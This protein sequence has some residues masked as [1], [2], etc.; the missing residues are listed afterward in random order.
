MERV[1]ALLEQNNCHLGDY[2]IYHRHIRVNG[3]PRLFF[4]VANGEEPGVIDAA[5]AQGHTSCL[6]FFVNVATSYDGR[7]AFDAMLATAHNVAQACNVHV[8]DADRNRLT[9]QHVE[10]LYERIH[11]IER[12]R[13]QHS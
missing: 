4:S 12:T 1:V 2:G 13:R 5:F 9:Q 10:Y 7:K 3:V 8:C 11:E 6:L